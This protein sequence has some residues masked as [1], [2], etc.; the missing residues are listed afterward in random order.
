[1]TYNWMEKHGN[2]FKIAWM[3]TVNLNG[4]LL[5][6]QEKQFFWD[7]QLNMDEDG[8]VTT[9]IH[10]NVMNLYLF[11][12]PHSA[13]VPGVLKGVIFG[14]IHHIFVLTNNLQNRQDTLQRF[15][16]RLIQHGYKKSGIK[17]IF[18]EG[19]NRYHNTDLTLKKLT[20]TTVFFYIS[21]T[22]QTIF[23]PISSRKHLKHAF[24]T[25]TTTVPIYGTSLR[26][27]TSRWNNHA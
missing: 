18:E 27:S 4:S 11:L 20:R 25:R 26:N 5:K 3:I 8:K 13:H 14:T 1:M 22:T 15:Y 21:R 12:P 23:P 19:I 7:L 2:P 10:E 6:G 9:K 17:T 16:L 24:W